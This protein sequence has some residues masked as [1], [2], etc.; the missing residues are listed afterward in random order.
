MA[1]FRLKIERALQA[2]HVEFVHDPSQT[3]DAILLIA[4]SRHVLPLWRAK[5]RGVRL[6]QRLDGLNWVQRARWNG[7][8]YEMRA[9]Y[10]N[11]IMNLY[12][13]RLAS[14]VVYQS[15]F[16]RGWW[17]AWYGVAPVPTAVILNGVDLVEYSPRPVNNPRRNARRLLVVE[18]SLAG[19]Q[20]DGLL[21]AVRLAEAL[22]LR[23]PTEVVVAGTVDRST[24]QLVVSTSRVPVQFL[25]VIAREQI[26]ELMRSADLLF[27]AEIN[28]PCPNSVIEALGCGLPVVGF[29]TGSLNELV[30]GDAG[31]LAP[32]RGDP[33][34]LETPELA[35]LVEAAE[36]VLMDPARFRREA[37]KRAEAGLGVEEMVD[38]YLKVL[39]EQ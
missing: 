28:P 29:D 39:L 7:I 25:G 6:V 8:R 23:D 32:Y 24:R 33:W 2:R 16:V 26:P 21:H 19:A 14:R 10:G 36:E 13:R 12:R 27:S 5:R 18:G 22:N 17:D 20:R 30:T 34:K 1:S 38:A 3:A 35:P 11:T 37:R 31:R 4:G 9:L 15:Q